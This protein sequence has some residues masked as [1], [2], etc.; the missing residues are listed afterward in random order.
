LKTYGAS[1]INT[2]ARQVC[3]QARGLLAKFPFSSDATQQASLADV[4]AVLKPGSGSLWRFYDE[5]LAAMLPRQGNVF[6]PN[7]AGTVKFS[8]GFVTLLNKAAA[9]SD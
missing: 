7:P 5:A 8:S 1:E 6:T 9:W 3:A 4:A 2:R